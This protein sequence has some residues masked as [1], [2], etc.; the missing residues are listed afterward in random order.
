MMLFVRVEK[1]ED[2]SRISDDHLRPMPRSSLSAR[3][4]RFFR[5]LRNAPRLRG[6]FF[7]A[8][9][10]VYSA[11]ASLSSSAGAQPLTRAISLRRRYSFWS[12]YTVV[13]CDGPDIWLPYMVPTL[14]ASLVDRDAARDRRGR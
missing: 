14:P 12:R 9:R 11:T 10:V 7:G 1:R 4:P 13:F 6:S 2:R 8:W 3:E 5:P